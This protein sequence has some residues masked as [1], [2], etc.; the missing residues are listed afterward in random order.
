MI[1]RGFSWIGP[2]AFLAVALLAAR[3]AHAQNPV[4]WMGNPRMAIDRAAEHSMPLMFWITEHEDVLD[5]DDVRDAQSRA[6]RDPTV[7]A[8]AQKRFVPV[9]VSRNNSVVMQEATKLGLPTDHGL[10]IAVISPEGKL[11]RTINPGDVANAEALAVHLLEALH[12]YLDDLYTTRLKP[13]ITDPERPKAEVRK[14]VQTVW[15]L[16][17]LTADADCVALLKRPDLSDTERSRLCTMLGAMATP[18]CI[19]ALLDLAAQGDKVAIQGLEQAEAGA[20]ATLLKALPTAEQPPDARQ[21]AA[22]RAACRIARV[23][24]KPD[25]FWPEA[26]PQQRSEA[27]DALRRRAEPILEY[28]SETTGQWR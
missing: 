25:T 8:L 16:G 11:I 9:R 20:L 15:R 7:V 12:A 14:A 26:Q 17:I 1:R 23:P 3:F 6:F 18:P 27:L 21:I 13:V 24:M 5:D 22:Y 4:Q 10:Y 19:E 28:W 2:V